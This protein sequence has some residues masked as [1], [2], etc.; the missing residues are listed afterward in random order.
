MA[1]NTQYK[2]SVSTWL[3][4]DED[5]L[6]ELYNA[7]SGS[8]YGAETP[9]V[10]NTL[11]GALFMD[12]IND[13][14]FT[15]GDKLVILIEHQSTV[16]QNMPLRFLLYIGRIYEKIIRNRALYATGL[17]KIPRP[18]FI[19]LYNGQ[20]DQ[21]DEQNLRLSDAFREAFP[22]E[23]SALE[24]CVRVL[25]VNQGRNREIMRRSGNLEGYA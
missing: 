13:L 20:R 21:P 5:R 23:G 25:N 24:L 9:L 7:I 18:E 19:V 1:T 6:R 16:N 10:I 8:N 17:V 14:S 3:F 2:N 22:G 15:L 11:E 4:S 12:R